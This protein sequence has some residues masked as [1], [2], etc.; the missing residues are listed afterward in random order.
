MKIDPKKIGKCIGRGSYGQVYKYGLNQALKLGYHEAGRLQA[1]K[2]YKRVQIKKPMT[3]VAVFGFGEGIDFDL[4]YLK[5]WRGTSSCNYWLIM[6]LLKPLNYIENVLI[7]TICESGYTLPEVLDRFRGTRYGKKTLRMLAKRVI[8]W[9]GKV[10]AEG[11]MYDIHS[12]N[13]MKTKTGQFKLID[14]DSFRFKRSR[15]KKS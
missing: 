7:S 15:G 1:I 13:V 3:M 11:Y 9:W 10:C 12:G 8:T 2:T 5:D 6:Q 4:T 14:L